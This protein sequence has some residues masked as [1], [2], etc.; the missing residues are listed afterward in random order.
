MNRIL[1]LYVAFMSVAVFNAKAQPESFV[2][3]DFIFTVYRYADNTIAY[4]S[5]SA[6]ST[7]IAGNIVIPDN[8]EY[9]G[10]VYEVKEIERY[11]FK[12]CSKM[13]AI[14]LPQLLH[15]IN[16]G[17]FMNCSGLKELHIPRWCIYFGWQAFTG[18]DNLETFTIAEHNQGAIV[19]GPAIYT[20]SGQ[21]LD[22]FAR[23][24]HLEYYEIPE[25]VTSIADFAFEGDK[26][27][28]TVKLPNSLS[29]LHCDIFKDCSALK[30]MTI[31][32]TIKQVYNAFPGCTAME[33]LIVRSIIPPDCYQPFDDD[34]Y[35]NVTLIIPTGSKEAYMQT[36]SW[37][38]FEHV[39]EIEMEDAQQDMLKYDVLSDNE[40]AVS[41]ATQNITGIITIPETVEID[42]K[43]YTVT[44]I[45][46]FI[47]CPRLEGVNMPNTIT[48]IMPIAFDECKA[49][50]TIH[51]P[52]SV[53]T[54][55]QGVF[56]NCSALKEITVDV[57]NPYLKVV[58]GL[59]M[60]A[61]GT[62]VYAYPPCYGDNVNIPE[63]VER[64]Q[65]GCFDFNDKIKKI[66]LPQSLV[67]LGSFE[68]CHS[69]EEINI[70]PLVDFIGL[71]TFDRC[72]LFTI[73]YEAAN[74]ADVNY[75][76]PFDFDPDIAD[77][78]SQA[79]LYVPKGRSQYFKN[80]PIWGKFKNI[81]ETEMDGI[82]I[83]ES[84]F[85]NIDDNKMKIGY[86][87]P[88]NRYFIE[89]WTEKIGY[90]HA[91]NCGAGI[92]FE[93]VRLKPYTGNELT[94]V[95]IS[96]VSDKIYNLKLNLSH[97]RYEAPFYS[98][99]IKDVHVGWNEVILNNPYY[100]DGQ[101]L[102]VSFSF[103][104]DE[105]CY[106]LYYYDDKWESGSLLVYDP[107]YY[108]ADG[109]K[110]AWL[111][112]YGCLIMQCLIE[113]DNLPDYDIHAIEIEKSSPFFEANSY[114]DNIVFS[115]RN[116]GKKDVENIELYASIDDVV[117]FS[118]GTHTLPINPML[119]F[120]GCQIGT[121][122]VNTTSGKHV[123][124][125]GIKTIN[126]K[127][128]SFP[129]DDFISVPIYVIEKDLGRHK[130]LLEHFSATWC[131][132]GMVTGEM[133]NDF[134]EN[135]GS[136]H[137][138]VVNI[139][140]GNDDYSTPSSQAYSEYRGIVFF[141][142]IIF[143][144]D[145]NLPRSQRLYPSL[146][147]VQISAHFSPQGRQLSLTVSGERTEDYVSLVGDATLTV[148]LVED[149]VKGRQND[150][151]QGYVDFVH[152]GVMRSCLSKIQGDAITWE[153]DRYSMNYQVKLDPSWKAENMRIVAFI[154]SPE[155]DDE[156]DALGV[157][158]CN[159]SKFEVGKLLG[160]VNCDG[161]VNIADTV[162]LLNYILGNPPAIFDE[163][164]ADINNNN[165]I[166]NTD[167][168]YLV[169][170]ILGTNK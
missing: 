57:N 6:A 110:G 31:L 21:T 60:S 87:P 50:E 80:A 168:E 62:E 12:D 53:K 108:L 15:S 109:T 30:E 55:E 83:P 89:N 129:E 128:P 150:R 75:T 20:S 99:E 39:K 134:M 33:S 152:Q 131:P 161:V 117:Y 68:L 18:C 23:G 67:D 16:D 64:I 125:A 94:A 42:G 22:A 2:R 95:R 76:G 24:Q 47:G 82:E 126:G 66:H 86:Y 148:L 72:N 135:M 70:P 7:E 145:S 136:D 164:V 65:L 54:L 138:S 45:E 79:T 56:R 107:D 27:L 81:V 106:S 28:K 169:N 165:A 142:R 166:D 139:H 147:N 5:V 52:A 69:L 124:K 153:D 73:R 146:A 40:V 32:K 100:I 51:L 59:V 44:T 167:V 1:F 91:G 74:P 58:E 133:V 34:F 157:I 113:G 123:I 98:Q 111:E 61:D 132:G 105:E 137:L 90:N 97:G 36:D 144:R 140:C 11:G 35:S 29:I 130:E 49:L 93:A 114:T 118:A 25:G 101:P 48:T 155:A 103:S 159:D 85:L 10:N 63:G 115:Y 122:P 17:S 120:S 13:T 92:E 160:D 41:V 19:I 143:D 37:N 170:I 127:T 3:G 104:Q 14:T 158:N 121:L 154:C 88:Y 78:Y 149:D 84:P 119:Y 141:P 116:W 77:I 71:H 4:F 8:V 156:K 162:C 9:E 96:L 46:N 151:E 102:L 26:N 163:S 43:S 38:R 112:K